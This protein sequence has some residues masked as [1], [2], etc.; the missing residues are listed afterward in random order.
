L[1]LPLGDKHVVYEAFTAKGESLPPMIF[2]PVDP[3]PPNDGG[4]YTDG[5]DKSHFAY[6][7]YWP[8]ISSPSSKTTQA[9]LDQMRDPKVV[10]GH[11]P[12]GGFFFANATHLIMD[13]ASWHMEKNVAADLSNYVVAHYF[14]PAAA[15][16]WLNACD[17]AINS[18]MRHCFA[19][20]QH[21]H[22][23]RKLQNIIA[24][25]YSVKDS[26]VLNSW[27]HTGLLSDPTT[28]DAKA[29]I[30]KRIEEG[31]HAPK[32][33]ESDF[34]RYRSAFEQLINGFVRTSD[35]LV[36]GAAPDMLDKNANVGDYWL[37]WG[38]RAARLPG[39]V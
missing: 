11:K 35:D 34:A 4:Y 23:H 9:W 19:K 26:T 31:Y 13:K 39:L 6:V 12:K 29:I 28:M 14:I 22:P 1:D 27:K 20:L 8:G 5:V 38:K 3:G 2:S 33:R 18:S 16:K 15:G 32:N 17:Q 36:P 25:Y 37:G 30:Q 10:N 7:E 21:E 24:A